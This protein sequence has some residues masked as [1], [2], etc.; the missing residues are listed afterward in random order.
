MNG[1]AMS[2]QVSRRDFVGYLATLFG[3]VVAE[4]GFSAESG[5]IVATTTIAA[6]AVRRVLGVGVGVKTLMGAGVDPHLYRAR[7]SDLVAVK[8]A[9]VLVH[10]GLGL[11]GRLGEL[12]SAAARGAV[13]VNLGEGV[14]KDRLI[15]P[16]AAS[17]VADPHIW[18]DP[19]VWAGVVEHLGGVLSDA[20][21]VEGVVAK[22][23]ISGFKAATEGLLAWG[24]AVLAKVPESG[25]VLVTSH[26]A[27]NY[28]GRAFGLR[29]VGLQGLSTVAEAGVADVSRLTAFIRK[30]G[31][32]A[33]FVE[34]SVPPAAMKRIA[35]LS[36]VR[37]GGELF[38]DSLG[39]FEGGGAGFGTDAEGTGG[40][41]GMMRHNLRT[42]AEGLA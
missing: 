16:D 1:C 5:E 27:F 35:E 32:K 41:L 10:H 14:S 13:V 42:V 11:E 31:V 40:Y 15:Y 24:R 26:D 21:V 4:Q 29:V 12:V 25:R 9:R 7:P 19:M 18:G 3:G 30:Q 36:G 8:R 28:L 6:D 37:V 20:G 17:A 2:K 23:G 38:S 39:G 34:S 33:V 22:A